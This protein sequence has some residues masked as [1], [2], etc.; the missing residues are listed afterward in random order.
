MRLL[1]IGRWIARIDDVAYLARYGPDTKFTT[2]RFA[3][4]VA[5]VSF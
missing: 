3:M 1:H 4:E 5:S 2:E